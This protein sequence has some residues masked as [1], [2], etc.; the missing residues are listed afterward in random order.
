M[1][2]NYKIFASLIIMAMSFGIIS[3]QHTV[4]VISTN[5][6]LMLSDSQITNFTTQAQNGD[7]EAAFHLY[8]YYCLIKL[9]RESAI[10]WASV[11]AQ[12][13]NISAQYEMG[14]FYN[15]QTYPELVN[16]NKALYWFKKAASNGDTNA[17]LRL[18]ELNGK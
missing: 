4:K 18:Q 13:G 11:S 15:G 12:N 16:T 2:S 14:M 5:Q 10:K 7:A 6:S 17:V 1:P 8:L 9:D 3:C